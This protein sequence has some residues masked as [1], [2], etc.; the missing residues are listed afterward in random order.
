M[1]PPIDTKYYWQAGPASS[2][3]WFDGKIC[4]FADLFNHFKA[5][6]LAA[7]GG[8]D[9][10]Q[11]VGMVRS[12]FSMKNLSRSIIP[13]HL[14]S[15]VFL[16]TSEQLWNSIEKIS[17]QTGISDSLIMA[18]VMQESTG[19]VRVKVGSIHTCPAPI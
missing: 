11:C 8:A 1:S 13:I 5:E 19:N 17:K 3:A 12:P 7:N 18:V 4:A 6:M 16:L 2:F 10:G 15:T 9:K 14:T